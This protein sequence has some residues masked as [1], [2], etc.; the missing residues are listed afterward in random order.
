MPQFLTFKHSALTISIFWALIWTALFSFLI[1]I[2]L[3]EWWE[4][5]IFLGAV[6]VTLVWDWFN[7]QNQTSVISLGLLNFLILLTPYWIWLKQQQHHFWL[8]ASF[9]FY[10]LINAALGFSIIISFKGFAH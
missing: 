9:A 7:I 8:T 2:G 4:Y 5:F 6:P 10:G 3:I 1:P